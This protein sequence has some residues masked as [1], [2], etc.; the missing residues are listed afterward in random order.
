M[1]LE[2]FNSHRT[3]ID[4]PSGKVAYVDVGSGPTALF[5]HGVLM[6][7]YLW[8]D[9]IGALAQER[10]CIALDLPAHGRTPADPGAD[11]TLPALADH[12]AS[13]CA[14]LELETV[15]L[16][17]ND[18]GGAVCQVFAARHPERLSTLALTNCDVHDQIPPEAFKPTVEAA[19]AGLMAPALVQ[20]YAHPEQ[21]RQA[22]AQGFEYPERVSDEA[23]HEYFGPFR[24]LPGARAAERAV[25]SLHAADLI[26]VEPQL[27][28]LETPTMIAW[29]NDDAF[30]EVK[31][32]YWLKDAIRGAERVIEIP[33]AKLFWPAERGAE[34]VPLLREHWAAH[35]PARANA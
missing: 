3:T 28:M 6:S 16:V 11:V 33:G 5:V 29:G 1:N 10:R 2:Q 31:W 35:A 25:T 30:F 27:A 21:A 23:I 7:S 26:A 19:R 32:A 22:L 15:D 4:T 34:L 12:L 14:A 20:L 17:G 9:V 13:L 24:T 8:A 18:T